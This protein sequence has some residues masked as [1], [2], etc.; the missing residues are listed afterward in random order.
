MSGSGKSTLIDELGNRGYRAVDLDAPEWSEWVKVEGNPTGANPGHDW[1]WREDRVQRLLATEKSEILFVSGCAEN[2]VNFYSQ[3][4]E[5]VLLSAPVSIIV[6]RLTSRTNNP[7]GQRPE[8][9]DRV[10]EHMRTIEPKLR[11]RA[12]HEIDTS[13][14]LDEVLEKVLTL[15]DPVK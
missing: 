11:R 1:R 15:A 3:F 13:A 7:Y 14:P 10:L 4:D 8:E 2:M 9:L 12:G 6:E 5:I